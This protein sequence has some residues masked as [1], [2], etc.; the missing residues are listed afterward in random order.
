MSIP[1]HTVHR[2]KKRGRG[3]SVI[4]SE[5]TGSRV[6]EEG[7]TL[8]I[9]L[10]AK[11]AHCCRAARILAR[12][13]E[14]KKKKEKATQ[15]CRDSDC[16]RRQ[17]TLSLFT[18]V[19]ALSI[20]DYKC[21]PHGL[22]LFGLLHHVAPSSLKLRPMRDTQRN[23][24]VPGPPFAVATECSGPFIASGSNCTYIR[25]SF[26]ELKPPSW[27]T[28]IPRLNSAETQP[29]EMCSSLTMFSL[30]LTL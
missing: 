13:R 10:W 2:A 29:S 12:N 22:V 24:R 4:K 6:I 30:S 8:V 18:A 11:W 23:S 19:I 26:V 7:R 1:R 25:W 14:E 28:V 5:L 9:F 21:T 16:K 27:P 20:T 17:V 15:L 3:G